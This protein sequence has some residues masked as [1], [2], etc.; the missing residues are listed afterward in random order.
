MGD[1]TVCDKV[2]LIQRGLQ[3]SFLK[4]NKSSLVDETPGRGIYDNSS[5]GG[6][7][8]RQ[9]G[10]FRETLSLHLLFFKCLHL[11]IYRSVIF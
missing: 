9:M 8:F 11:E 6:S 3:V 2:C 5:K 7:V 10:G 4:I 1:M